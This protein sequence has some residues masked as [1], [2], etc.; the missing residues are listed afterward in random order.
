MSRYNCRDAT[1]FWL[2]SVKDLFEVRGESILKHRIPTGFI[3]DDSNFE[4]D[5]GTDQSKS[6]LEIV[7]E[8]IDRHA[9]GIEFVERNAGP[10]VILTGFNR[11]IPD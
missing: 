9:S 7:F 1:W 8:I 3:S 6:V 10:K 2:N 5:D 11:F 4:I